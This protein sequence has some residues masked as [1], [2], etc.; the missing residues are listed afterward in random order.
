MPGN[1]SPEVLKTYV[2]F[3]AVIQS[4]EFLIYWEQN[5]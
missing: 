2:Y 3:L 1:L 4:K 5:I